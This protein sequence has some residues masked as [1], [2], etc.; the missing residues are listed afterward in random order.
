MGFGSFVSKAAG[1]A[2]GGG[3]G[4]LLGGGG[5]AL[6]GGLL[7]G[8]GLGGG[9]LMDLLRG[10]R[11]APDPEAREIK[12]L[13]LKGLRSISEQLEAAKGAPTGEAIA[14]AQI[15]RETKALRTAAEDTRRRL[16][17]SIARRGLG[18]T[19]AGLAQEVGIGRR[20]AEQTG[21]IKASLPERIR[22]ERLARSQRIAGLGAALSGQVGQVPI[23]FREERKGGLAPLVGAGLG[24]LLGGVGGAQ[25]GAG[26]GTAFLRS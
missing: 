4:G 10:R 24:G 1:V 19:T 13:K 26:L 7:K 11:I 12:Q 20:L 17:E 25:V 16:R 5:G 18:G 2:T 21:A 9:S 8:F 6:T 15:A 23:R 3:I 14:G 22:Q